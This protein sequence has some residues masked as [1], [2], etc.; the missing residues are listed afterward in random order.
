M[1][2]I[3]LIVM[4]S[5]FRRYCLRSP[6]ALRALLQS[7]LFARVGLHSLSK[8]LP[9]H[10]LLRL[11]RYWLPLSGDGLLDSLLRLKRAWKEIA[12]VERKCRLDLLE[13]ETSVTV[14]VDGSDA[15]LFVLTPRGTESIAM[16]KI[17]ARMIAAPLPLKLHRRK[18]N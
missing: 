12:H 11:T 4:P 14:K 18:N 13:I 16:S 15:T 1:E 7:L 9:A 3:Q 6:V 10:F 2:A 17:A 8:Y 5:L